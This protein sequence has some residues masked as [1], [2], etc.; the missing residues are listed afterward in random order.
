M[1]IFHIAMLVIT[2]GDDETESFFSRVCDR[3]LTPLL[4]F[5]SLVLGWLK[6]N[7]STVPRSN[8]D[9]LLGA[10]TPALSGS[11]CMMGCNYTNTHISQYFTHLCT[12][13]ID[14]NRYKY[15]PFSPGF[16]IPSFVFV[17]P[18]KMSKHQ[19]LFNSNLVCFSHV[20]R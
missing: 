19:K 2:R 1:V 3:C 15:H 4:M 8:R 5:R 11:Q 16:P 20:L 9:W 7:H 17:F 6:A 12:L 13:Y 14:I 18:K 10:S